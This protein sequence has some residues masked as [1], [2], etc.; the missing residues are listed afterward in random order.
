MLRIITPAPR[1]SLLSTDE[2]IEM[3]GGD[4]LEAN[5]MERIGR[6][7][8]AS[9]AAYCRVA[10]GGERTLM[11][12]RVE[13]TFRPARGARLMLSRRHQV[14]VVS[15]VEDGATLAGADYQLVPEYDQILR[16]REGEPVEWSAS[17]V[18]V[19]YDAG[20]TDPPSDLKMAAGMYARLIFAERS[21]DPMVKGRETD[22]PGVYRERLEYWV[23][24]LPGAGKSGGVPDTVAGLLGPYV[25]IVL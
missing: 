5:T 21:R 24:G 9:I 10:G 17:K 14:A 7:V 11:R 4:Y 22:V 19:T 18:V 20:F 25:N 2:L 15:V 1:K 6:E 16:L 12:E 8:S 23:G 13:E 3:I